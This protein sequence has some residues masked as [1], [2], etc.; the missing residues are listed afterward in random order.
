MMKNISSSYLL[1]AQPVAMQRSGER[2]E[3]TWS[4][5]SCFPGFGHLNPLLPLARAYREAGQR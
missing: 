2:Y 4:L 1:R 5:F 3:P